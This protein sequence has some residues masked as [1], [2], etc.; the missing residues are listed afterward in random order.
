MRKNKADTVRIES[1]ITG[2]APAVQAKDYDLT[3]GMFSEDCKFDS[4]SLDNLKRSFADL[5][6]LPSPPDMTKLY[7]EAFLPKR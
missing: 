5:N 2:N 7:T 1:Q 6:I 4:E 3:V